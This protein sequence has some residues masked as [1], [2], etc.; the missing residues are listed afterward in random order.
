L[1]AY[2]DA[3]HEY[4]GRN[5]R[6]DEPEFAQRFASHVGKRDG[7]YWP[8]TEGEQESPFGPL[9]ARATA[10][11]YGGDLDQEPPEPFHG[12]Y[13]KILK[14]QGEHADGGVFDYVVQG[15]M[16]LGFALVA[17]PASYGNSGI[18]TF[19]VNQ[20]GVIYEQDLGPDTAEIGAAMPIFDPDASWRKY[21]ESAER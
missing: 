4:A 13:F 14:A 1:Q 2:V 11:G 8:V 12:Y 5:P 15:K 7:L 16:V 17:F 19:I 3:Q 10:E 6:N 9:I 21:Q 20:Q 18:M